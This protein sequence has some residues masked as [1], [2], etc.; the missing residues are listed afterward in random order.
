MYTDIYRH[1]TY[2]TYT[3]T[4]TYTNILRY[5]IWKQKKLINNKSN[6]IM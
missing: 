2:V 1:V 6:E 4:V 5:F 3:D